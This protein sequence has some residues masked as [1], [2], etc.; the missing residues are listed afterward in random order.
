METDKQQQQQKDNEQKEKE[1]EFT[2]L[3]EEDAECGICKS[4]MRHPVS[5]LCGHTFCEVCLY[6]HTES[7]MP[8]RDKCPLCRARLPRSVPQVNIVL[9][10]VLHKKWS[11]T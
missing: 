3:T 4:V 5:V 11:T 10:D 7:K 1:A 6:T 8:N 9:R 2:K